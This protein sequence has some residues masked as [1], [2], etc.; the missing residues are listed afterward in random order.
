M[1][2]HKP[3]EYNKAKAQYALRRLLTEGDRPPKRGSILNLVLILVLLIF[4]KL[5]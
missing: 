1:K 5:H 2:D 3:P 4:V